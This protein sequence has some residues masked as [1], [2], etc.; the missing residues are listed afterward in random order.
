MKTYFLAVFFTVFAS[1]FCFSQIENISVNSKILNDSR[2]IKVQ[3]PRNYDFQN[4]R[5]YPLIFVFDGHYLFEPV[6]GI[7]D[8]LSYWEE[9]PDA[10]VVGINQNK[11]RIEDGRYDDSD[12]LP[13]GSGASFFD[14]VQ[15][16]VMKYIKENYNVGGFSVVIGHDYMANFANFYLFSKKAQF[17]GYINL[18]PDIPD[19]FMPYIKDNLEM[20]KNKLWYSL[21]TAKEDVPFLKE[22]TKKLSEM[23]SSVEN[24]MVTTSYKMFESGN[25]YTFVVNALPF[26][27]LE[28]FS[29]YT[30]IDKAEY[31]LLSKAENPN[32][33]LIKKYED[34]NQMYDLDKRVR[35]SDIMLVD[36]LIQEKE[37]WEFYEGLA[38][39]AQKEH[40]E[41]LLFDYF[42]GRYFQKIGNPKKAIKAYQSAYSYEE[43]GGITKDMLLEEAARLKDIFGY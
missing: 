26:N 8:Y 42:L 6:A 4:K 11:S 3:L 12:F 19:G 30:P 5:T 32:E 18:S 35:I 36:K 22:K 38:K 39:I 37:A 1:S 16:E 41:T 25:H 34:I 13:I 43:A 40:P 10:F 24:D 17:Q 29:P 7:V 14:F 28:I 33:Y 2:E 27:L 21:S 15:L 23:I 20:S 31:E 9:I